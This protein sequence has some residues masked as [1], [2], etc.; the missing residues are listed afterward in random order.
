MGHADPKGALLAL[1]ATEVRDRLASGALR[2]VELVE[3]CLARI[4]AREP[5]VRAWAFLDGAH[6]LAQARALDARRLSGAP[7]G[8][9]HG[10]PV[11][12]KDVI[13]VRGMPTGHGLADRAGRV[14]QTDA[15]VAARLRAAGAILIGK[16]ATAEAAFLEPPATRNP[17]DPAR[18]PG[19]SSSGS[20]A[21]VAAGMVPLAIGTQTGGSVIRPA[22]FCGITGFKPSFGLIPRTGVLSQSP[23]LDTMGVFGRSVEDVALLAEALAG[24]DPADPASEPMPAPRLPETAASAPPVAPT[25]ALVRP[26]GWEAASEDMRLALEELASLLGRDCIALDLPP[27]F[28]AAADLRRR[29]N[30]A[31]MAHHYADL[32]AQAPLSPLLRDALAEGRAI[33]ATDY[34][35]ALDARSDLL[36]GLAPIFHRCDAILCPAA[37]GPAPGRE[38]TGDAIFNGLWTLC[39][40]PA[41]T[42]PLFASSEGLPMGAQLVGP[43]GGDARLLR[44]A[45]WLVG[46]L[47]PSPSASETAP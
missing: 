4:A 47:S 14:A 33:P 27:S 20:A 31:E 25:L 46:R 35:R 39:G 26:P 38:T 3:A 8:P 15:F 43:R 37:S 34:L 41:I 7:I 45:R 36:A 12:V 2:A 32:E 23:N 9:L 42:L 16:T 21:A 40:L 11:G 19:G 44:T 28:G 17:H 13:D 30:L 22:A 10:L 24:H 18:T 6:A 1:P 29:I 5:D